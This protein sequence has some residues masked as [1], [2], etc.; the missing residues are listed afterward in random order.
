M[1]GQLLW[2]HLWISALR[3][4]HAEEALPEIS[5]F[6]GGCWGGAP[7]IFFFPPHI[8]VVVTGLPV[9]PTLLEHLDFHSCFRP[10]EA[11]ESSVPFCDSPGWLC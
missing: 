11:Q 1:C 2:L 4:F 6:P 10:R 7:A 5:S 8:S 9:E 3:D